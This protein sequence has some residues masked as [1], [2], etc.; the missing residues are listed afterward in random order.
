MVL[1]AIPMPDYIYKISLIIALMPVAS[2]TAVLTRRFGGSPSFAA[3]A[4][5]I[6]HVFA[7]ITVPTGLY[8]LG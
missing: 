7:I 8:I 2:S 5:V 6:T 1:K 3:A 4:A